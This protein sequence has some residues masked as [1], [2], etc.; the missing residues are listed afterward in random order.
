LG[1]DESACR[2]FWESVVKLA[3]VGKPVLFTHVE[4]VPLLRRYMK[5]K[6]A[7]QFDALFRT[8]DD[9]DPALEWCE[10]RVL[11]AALP[12][13]S[14]D[15]HV[16]PAQGELLQRLT[17]EEIAVIT[18]VLRRR[19]YRRGESI[20]RAGEEAREMFFLVRGNVSVTVPLSAGTEKRLATF[21]AGMVFGEMA[22][23][24][25]A[26]RS[27]RIVADTD[28]ECDVLALE[29]FNGLGQTHPGIKI[30]LL[31]NLCLGF[32]GKLRKANRQ[33]SVLE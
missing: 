4:R 13:W 21:S 24:D 2:L 20:I 26:P 11:E 6:L 17:P 18:G 15:R 3:R 32:C 28:V 1:L 5:A 25:G 12:G 31:E 22:V 19:T 10:N 7:A 9:L 33:V 14:L 23:L 29:D 16:E 27:A 30:K 8:F